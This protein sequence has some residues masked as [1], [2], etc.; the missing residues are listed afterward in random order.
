[1]GSMAHYITATIEK[2][3]PMNV[4][5]GLFPELPK[6]LKIKKKEMNNMAER[7]LEQFKTL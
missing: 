2:F 7:A 6:K 4:N 1:M 5:F 3:Q